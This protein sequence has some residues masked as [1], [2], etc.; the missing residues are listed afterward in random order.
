MKTAAKSL[1]TPSWRADDSSPTTVA[2][3]TGLR[4]HARTYWFKLMHPLLERRGRFR[5]HGVQQR[6]YF[7]MPG[8][9]VSDVTTQFGTFEREEIRVA[10]HLC[11]HAFGADALARS[12]L[13]DVGCHI[14]NYSVELGPSFGRIIALDAVRTFTHVTQANLAWN[15]LADKAQVIC[16]AAAAR[17]GRVQLQLD[18]M[19]NLGHARVMDCADST[20]THGTRVD[21]VDLDS[22]LQRLDAGRITF[23]K[24]DVEGGEVAV[25]AGASAIIRQHQP[26]IQAEVNKGHLASVVAQVQHRGVSYSAWR[27]VRGAPV[28]RSLP[29]RVL[30]ILLAGGNRVYLQRLDPA[31]PQTRNLPCV[32]LIPDMLQLPLAKLFP[33]PAE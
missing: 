26:I 2:I 11:L 5:L 10:R 21:A 3:D 24:I 8:D 20:T 23:I 33:M 1:V 17:A 22:L 6:R 19:G 29:R 4:I 14:G 7:V 30:T 32:F 27:L 18:R 25:L 9:W 31:S 12:T 13:V 15:G 28:R 16:A